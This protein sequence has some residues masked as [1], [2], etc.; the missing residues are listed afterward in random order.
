[1]SR[2][3]I[4]K[5]VYTIRC[6]WGVMVI[7]VVLSFAL[8]IFVLLVP[9]HCIRHL[10]KAIEVIFH[11][12]LDFGSHLG[13]AERGQVDGACTDW[14]KRRS[15]IILRID[16]NCGAVSAKLRVSGSNRSAKRLTKLDGALHM[17]L[18][19]GVRLCVCTEGM[20]D[21]YGL[22]K[23]SNSPTDGMDLIGSHVPRR[24][25][26]ADDECF[27]S[28]RRAPDRAASSCGYRRAIKERT[29]KD[30]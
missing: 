15:K 20:C 25:N 16:P 28:P 21:W 17:T 3:I 6:G 30:I 13:G 12:L 14:N 4:L 7:I 23:G 5:G 10:R 29:T 27:R 18:P 19:G 24:S 8:E 22:W 11:F 1:M 26:N 2:D 9:V